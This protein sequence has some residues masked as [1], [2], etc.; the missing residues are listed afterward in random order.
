MRS[1]TTILVYFY[2]CYKR[3]MWKRFKLKFQRKNETKDDNTDTQK[4]SSNDRSTSNDSIVEH[5]DNCNKLPQVSIAIDFGTSNCAAAFSTESNRNKIIVIAQWTDGLTT[6]GKIPTLILFNK[7]QKF[8]AFGNKAFDEYK[9]LVEE[10]EHED[11]Y[12]FENFK[13]ILYD[14]KVN[15]K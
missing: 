1:T 15:Q 5:K 11:Y 6:N 13:M 14:E 4:N 8:V 12:Y 7:E 10:N 3:K 9:E 2:L